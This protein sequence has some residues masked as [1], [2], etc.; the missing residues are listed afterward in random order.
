MWE[1]LSSLGSPEPRNTLSICC[2]FGLCHNEEKL[3]P[4]PPESSAFSRLAT[5]WLLFFRES[6]QRS[7]KQRHSHHHSGGAHCPRGAQVT[8]APSS[9]PQYQG[10]AHCWQLSLA[11]SLLHP[12]YIQTQTRHTD[13]CPSLGTHSA[14]SATPG[15]PCHFGPGSEPPPST[16]YLL[17]VVGSSCPPATGC[18]Q[19]QSGRGLE[20]FPEKGTK[21][22][23]NSLSGSH[24]A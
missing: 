12:S 6:H 4:M 21:A 16:G 2:L 7:R 11:R 15:P 18:W 5:S 17:R 3:T 10:P 22:T 9:Q 19:D 24:S 20:P 1:A 8:P 23:Q 14:T 13:L